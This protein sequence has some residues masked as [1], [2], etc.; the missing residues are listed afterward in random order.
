MKSRTALAL[1]AVCG[2]ALFVIGMLAAAPDLGSSSMLA[3]AVAADPATTTNPGT[4]VPGSPGAPVKA[5]KPGDA[6]PADVKPSDA[7]KAPGAKTPADAPK[8]NVSPAVLSHTIKTIDGVDKNLADFKGQVIVIVNV[9]SKCG[10]TSQYEGL[11]Q[12]YKENKDRGFVVLG[13]PANNFMSQEPGSNAEIKQFCESKFGVTFPMFEKISVKGDDT[14]PLYRQL[15]AQ[16]A[17]IGGEPK[18]NFTKFVIDREGTVVARFDAERAMLA[19]KGQ[20]E[21]GLIKKVQELLKDTN[22]GGGERKPLPAE[23]VE[24]KKGT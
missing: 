2:G 16:P 6:K 23:K 12:L 1:T 18:W 14:H 9:A 10:F 17:P 20:L 21:E 4:P 24:P 13:F 8:E 11:E 22:P 5:P 3:A 7:P 15:A 19:K